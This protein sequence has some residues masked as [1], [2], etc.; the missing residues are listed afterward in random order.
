AAGSVTLTLTTTGNGLCAA[1][2]D[3]VVVTVT[4]APVVSAG[5]DQTNCANDLS[6]SL[7]GSVTGTATTGIWSTS[8]TGHFTPSPSALNATYLA[9]TADSLAGG[10]TLTRVTP[11]A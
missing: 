1:V 6:V 8:G 7:N 5:A 4:A 11:P 3:A 2:G 9:S 10:V